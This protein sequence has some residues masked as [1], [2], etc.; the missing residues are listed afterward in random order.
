MATNRPWGGVAKRGA[1]NVQD[2]RPPRT[3]HDEKRAKRRPPG[4]DQ[5]RWV[6]EGASAAV[7][8]AKPAPRPRPARPK[9][10]PA[11]VAEEVGK[12]AGP[13]WSARVKERLG[14]AA[15]AYEAER[16]RDAR[17]ILEPLLERAPSATAVRELL[18]LTYYRL[19]K[20]RDA[21]RELGAVELLTGTVDHHPV[22]AD[23]HRALGHLDDVE[24]LWDE[25]RRAGA[26]VDVVIEGRIVTAGA[27]ADA[28]R[29]PDAVRLLEQGPIDVRKPK[30][31]HLRLL[32]ALAA[33]YE[34]AGDVGASRRMFTRLVVAAPD[35]A[36]AADRLASL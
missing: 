10:V 11:E 35:F 28:G 8:R 33:T 26:G 30:E 17:R 7:T 31:H 36:D 3:D 5:D 19:G 13:Q 29:I 14:E 1:R 27:L 23:C 12:A 18:G 2:P 22:I 15:A 24:R 6:R 25:L 9:T 16:Y 4:D 34:R 21:I 20:W 32:Y